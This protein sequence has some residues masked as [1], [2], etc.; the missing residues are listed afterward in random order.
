MLSEQTAILNRILQA[1]NDNGISGGV[2]DFI[3]APRAYVV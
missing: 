2:S 1:I 3:A